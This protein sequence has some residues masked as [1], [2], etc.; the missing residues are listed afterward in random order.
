M[1]TYEVPPYK[2]PH[3]HISGHSLIFDKMWSTL[4]IYYLGDLLKDNGDWKEMG[5][6]STERCTQPTIRRLTTNLQ[7]AKIFFQHYY[8]NLLPQGTPFPLYPPFVIQQPN[9]NLTPLPIP[10]HTLYKISLNLT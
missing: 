4:N 1:T 10:K 9:N 8:P 5:H 7:I 3:S 2:I 6:I